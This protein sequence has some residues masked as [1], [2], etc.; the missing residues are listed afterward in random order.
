MEPNRGTW[1]GYSNR[2]F[3]ESKKRIQES[4]DYQIE[5]EEALF[6]L[7]LRNLTPTRDAAEVVATAFEN[8]ADMVGEGI[9]ADYDG[10]DKDEKIAE[11]RE[12]FIDF[13]KKAAR[14]IQGVR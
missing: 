5:F 14:K 1:K 6:E 12:E 4:S 11:A 2:K 8:V 13:A 3:T 7:Y 9:E 10:S